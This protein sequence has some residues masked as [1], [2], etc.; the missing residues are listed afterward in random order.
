MGVGAA[1]VVQAV[2]IR[3]ALAEA[4]AKAAD[5]FPGAVEIGTG[6][7]VKSLVAEKGEWDAAG[8]NQQ[9]HR[10]WLV[11]VWGANAPTP[12]EKPERGERAFATLANGKLQLARDRTSDPAGAIDLDGVDVRLCSPLYSP[13]FKHP[14]GADSG[15]EDGVPGDRP[16]GRPIGAGKEKRWWKRLPIVLSHPERA[17]H[18]GHRVVWCY[19]LSDAAK[20]AWA[21]ALWQDVSRSRAM[22]DAAVLS[23]ARAASRLS[24]GSRGI[25]AGAGGGGIGG[26]GAGD[27]HRDGDGRGDGDEAQRTLIDHL[28]ACVAVKNSREASKEIDDEAFAPFDRGSR[29]NGEDER[30]GPGPGGSAREVGW[31]SGGAAA[32]A[33]N[34][35]FTRIIFDM[36]R[37]PE[38]IAEVRRDL[39]KL[40]EGIPDLPKFIGPISV[41]RVHLGENVPQIRAARLPH[42][43]STAN[44]SS[45]APWD[46]GTLANRGP[47]AAVELEMDFAGTAEVVLRTNIDLNVYAEMMREKERTGVSDADDGDGTNAD[48]DGTNT[49]GGDGGDE[50]VGRDSPEPSSNSGTNAERFAKFKSLAKNNASKLIGAV[51]KKLVDVPVTLRVRLRRLSGTMRF[52]IPPPPGDR[53]WFAF[54]G[55]PKVEMQAI[56]TLGD[57]GIR[58]HGLADKV[59]QL[60][61]ANLLKE[62][63]AALVLPNAGNLLLE[64]LRPYDGVIPEIDIDV[65]VGLTAESAAEAAAAARGSQPASS[66]SP[67]KEKGE[68]KDEEAAVKERAGS[69]PSPAA[70]SPPAPLVMPEVRRSWGAGASSL[71]ASPKVEQ[72]KAEIS[73][74]EDYQRQQQQQQQ[75]QQ[76][77][78]DDEEEEEEGPD[79]TRGVFHTPSNSMLLEMPAAADGD[80]DDDEPSSPSAP[81]RDSSFGEA[82]A[83]VAAMAAG[84]IET[85]IQRFRSLENPNPPEDQWASPTGPAP[86]GGNV[87][88]EIKADAFAS[89]SP[90][91]GRFDPLG[92]DK[93]NAG[94]ASSSAASTDSGPT[95]PAAG[96]KLASLFAKKLNTAKTRM[97]S[98]FDQLREGIKKGGLEGGFDAAVRIT[99]KAVKELQE[100]EKPKVDLTKVYGG[101]TEIPFKVPEDEPPRTMNRREHAD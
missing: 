80:G 30:G 44:A 73:L 96:L 58:W 99:E 7:A 91:A 15:T 50:K 98:D 62:L 38:K 11:L 19:A 82:E 59:S 70:I 1:L 66:S 48:A 49:G 86:A 53:L 84:A 68:D 28:R 60:I 94:G 67:E 95:N 2:L 76:D 41:T 3:L 23:A 6:T 79:G 16:G 37:S 45:A 10:G 24:Q 56:P 61:T 71:P 42:A 64:P 4:A 39:S 63:Y 13:G 88:S 31:S 21:V 54:V 51:A 25:G 85:P 35:V 101:G 52:W 32:A 14:E 55:E 87:L 29:G 47:C 81:R 9:H 22:M 65:V 92:K 77:E 97:M 72:G 89:K 93:D 17:L 90:G 18:K 43:A 46:G 20:E 26:D 27:R 78:D 57:L 36:Q 5:E 34:G 100:G 83:A 40:C 33:L 12:P 75:Q 8:P 69:P 74:E